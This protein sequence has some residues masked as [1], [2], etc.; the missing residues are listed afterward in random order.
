MTKGEN[1]LFRGCPETAKPP[2]RGSL[3]TAQG[4]ALGLMREKHLSP[5]GAAS[6][7]WK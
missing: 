1:R 2:Q 7:F 6:T 4:N 5:N 3:K